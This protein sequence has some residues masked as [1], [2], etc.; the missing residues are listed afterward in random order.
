MDQSGIA[1]AGWVV[2]ELAWNAGPG[3]GRAAIQPLGAE[4]YGV[5]CHAGCWGRAQGK[6]PEGGAQRAGYD[7]DLGSVLLQEQV[8]H[9]QP[10]LMFSTW[11]GGYLAMGVEAAG[12]RPSIL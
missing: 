3:R 11:R 9:R 8:C 1:H 4:L 7:A 6:P 12:L 2:T 10:E 5:A